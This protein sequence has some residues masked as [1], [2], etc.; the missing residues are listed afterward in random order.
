MEQKFVKF[1]EAIEKLGI[2][3]ER[4]NQLR[5]VGE[6]RA[7]RDG[8]SWKFRSDEIER[9]VTDGIPDPPPPSDISL[10]GADDLVESSPFMGLDDRDDRKLA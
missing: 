9:M 10:V 2:S 4:L 3:A 7:Y 8:S 1:E 6:L 5:E